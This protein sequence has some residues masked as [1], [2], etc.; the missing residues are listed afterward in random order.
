MA[1]VALPAALP[2]ALAASPSPADGIATATAQPADPF[3][4]LLATAN[5]APAT[6]ASLAPIAMPA[7]TALAQPVLMPDVVTLPVP[8]PVPPI[9]V[10][11]SVAPGTLP[12]LATDKKGDKNKAGTDAT[13]EDPLADAIAS[14]ATAVLAFAPAIA[15]VTPPQTA[16]PTPI[17]IDA[18]MIVPRKLGA[19]GAALPSPLPVDTAPQPI[20][21]DTATAQKP[22]DTAIAGPQ[23]NPAGAAET[24]ADMAKAAQNHDAPNAQSPATPAVATPDKPVAAPLSPET[25]A[26]VIAALKQGDRTAAPAD[27]VATQ[28]PIPAPASNAAT[29]AQRPVTQLAEQETAAVAAPIR[30]RSEDA[31]APRAASAT[32]KRLDTAGIDAAPFGLAQPAAERPPATGA[33]MAAKGD[34]IVEQSLSIARDGVW[35]DTLARDIASSA[36]NGGDLHFKLNPQNLG[37]LTVAIAQTADG[38]SI[39]LTATTET[40]RNILL[41][42]QPRLVAEARAQGLKVSDTQVD[43][44]SNQH[45]SSNQDASRWTQGNAGQN[46][47]AQNGQ[48]RQSSPAH[49]PFVSN[50]GRRSD[51]ESESPARDSDALY[52]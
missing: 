19:M 22:L 42:A 10:N 48:N 29:S 52:A 35:L 24:A 39:R 17:A 2:S 41:D 8:A 43:L 36:S 44:S 5:A 49:Q 28:A 30:R 12:S 18:P 45:Q 25:L 21:T 51:A 7:A 14:G 4:A 37:S 40:T 13:R 3:A 23:P 50:L 47:T 34:T 11:M 31:A 46:G 38:A 20:A 26:A 15:T 32:R 1:D 9:A 33:A 16:L 27:P 6:G